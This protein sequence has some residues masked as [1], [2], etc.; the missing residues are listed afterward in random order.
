MRPING[1]LSGPK[2]LTATHQL[3]H[4]IAAA[5]EREIEIA[6]AIQEC[7]NE[8]V[9][10]LT[11]AIHERTNQLLETLETVEGNARVKRKP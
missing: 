2:G 7:I 5:A 10:K 3:S 4:T 6:A 1:I 9:D 8:G 11:E